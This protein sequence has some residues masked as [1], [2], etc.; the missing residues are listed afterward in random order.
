MGEAVLQ[1]VAKERGVDLT[2]DSAGTAAYHTGEEPDER[3][4]LLLIYDYSV[5]MGVLSMDFMCADPFVA[6]R[7]RHVARYAYIVLR[8]ENNLMHNPTID[9]STT[10][11]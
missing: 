4:V 11:S 7:W 3:L 6:G 1:H 5:R 2:V 9:Y 8:L 10:S